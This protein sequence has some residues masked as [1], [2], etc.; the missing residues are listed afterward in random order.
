MGKPDA[1]YHVELYADGRA[2]SQLPGAQRGLH[3]TASD[4]DAEDRRAAQGQA[5]RPVMGKP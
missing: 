4:A 1:G 3:G 2:E 5:E